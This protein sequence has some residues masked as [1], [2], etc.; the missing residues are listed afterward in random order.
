MKNSVT[1]FLTHVEIGLVRT[2][3]CSYGCSQI[4]T[5]W[6]FFFKHN[7]PSEDVFI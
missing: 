7:I 3:L 5:I 4:C 6:L 1:I 2:V